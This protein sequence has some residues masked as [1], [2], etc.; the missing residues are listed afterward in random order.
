MKIVRLEAENIKRLKA[1]SITPHGNVVE[2]TGRNGQGKTSVL[3]AIWWALAGVGNIQETPIRKGEQ[4]ARIRLDLGELQVTRTFRATKEGEYTTSIAVESED[5]ARYPSPQTMLD[6]LLGKLAFDPLAFAR[7]DARKQVDLLKKFVPGIDFD[8]IDN[9]NAGD[10]AR[11]T[12]ANR[13]A[14]ELRAAAAA[15][16]ID[17]AIEL[18]EV[19]ESALMQRLVDAGRI[20]SEVAEEARQRREEDEEREQLRRKIEAARERFSLMVKAAA[21]RPPAKRPID[22]S[23][24]VQEI[25]DAKATNEAC[26]LYRDR[27]KLNRQADAA[28]RE[29]ERLTACMAERNDQ[30]VRAVAEAKLPVAGL[31]FGDGCV[32]VSGLPFSQASDAEQLRVSTALAM[33]GRGKLSVVRIRDGSLLDEDSL[34]MVAHMA[35]QNDCQVWIERVDASGKVGFTVEDGAVRD[36]GEHLGAGEKLPLEETLIAMNPHKGN[37]GPKPRGKKGGAA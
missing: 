12:E 5:G 28:D 15:I 14:K 31:G 22:V 3:D 2:I 27:E 4:T 16:R 19:D 7:M 10:Y 9:A 17:P 33:A 13:K 6:N 20:N 25:E 30:K 37:G 18:V 1:V 32:T 26:A 36:T 21:D 11:R 8:A 35:D 23:S 24:L 34:K 29:V